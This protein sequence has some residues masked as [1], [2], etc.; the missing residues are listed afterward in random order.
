MH[1]SIAKELRELALTCT[2]PGRDGVWRI[3]SRVVMD[4]DESFGPSGDNRF[5]NR[6]RQ[7]AGGPGR[8]ARPEAPVEVSAV[9]QV[10]ARQLGVSECRFNGSE[11]E[12]RVGRRL[13]TIT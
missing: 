12:E 5:E 8:S 3:V 2:D 13:A 4:V 7:V 10:A 9:R 1:E 6:L 11:Y